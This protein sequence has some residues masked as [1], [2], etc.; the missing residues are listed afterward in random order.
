MHGQDCGEG[1]PHCR[2]FA[3][4]VSTEAAA[5]YSREKTGLGQRVETLLLLSSAH[6]LNYFYSEYWIDAVIRAP[7]GTANHLSV[8]NQVFPTAD[9]SVVIIVPASAPFPPP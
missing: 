3:G 9:G 7:M 4:F 6:L 5:L 2:P 8:P 1:S